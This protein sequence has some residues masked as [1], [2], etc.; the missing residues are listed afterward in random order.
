MA[1]SRSLEKQ[2]VKR[3]SEGG[4]DSE[5]TE[6]ASRTFDQ[7]TSQITHISGA[8]SSWAWSKRGDISTEH[9]SQ[10]TVAEQKQPNL[11]ERKSKEQ[12]PTEKTVE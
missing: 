6:L 9:P 1:R 2:R 7:V 3:K 5:V 11:A 8:I 10:P 12:I 4:I